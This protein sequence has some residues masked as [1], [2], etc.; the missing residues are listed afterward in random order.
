MVIDNNTRITGQVIH[1]AAV[2]HDE[3]CRFLLQSGDAMSNEFNLERQSFR[4]GQN[5]YISVY[6]C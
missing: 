2:F 3:A 4:L 1:R 5:L 6:R